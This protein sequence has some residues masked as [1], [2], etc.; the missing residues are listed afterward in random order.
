MMEAVRQ[1]INHLRQE[2]SKVI[3][4]QQV[5]CDQCVIALLCRGHALLEG[6]PGVAKTLVV[7]TLS[8]IL[9]LKFQR[10]QCTPDL[11]PADIIGTNVLN[12]A[13][14]AFN[15]HQGPV[16]TDLLL[17]DEVNRMPPRTQAGLLECM[18]E[19][20][21]TIDG[22]CCPL[23]PV[24]TVFATQNPI[25]FEGTYPL[26]EAQLDR[27]LLKVKVD[28]PG[29]NDEVQ[30]LANVQNGF[31]ARDLNSVEWAPVSAEMLVE[32]Q[33]EI[34]A[35]KVEKTLFEYIVK[36]IRLTRDWPALSLGASPRAAIYLMTVA[37]AMA[38]M[39]GRDFLIPDDVKSAA[40]PVLRHR[41]VLRPEA[42]LE[43]VTADQ[44]VAE[45]LRAVEVPK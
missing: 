3:V 45:I 34:K 23:S 8:R 41:I 40:P 4:G 6:A 33:E 29:A 27:F 25:E 38:A 17:V 22:V 9:Q 7:K 30:L 28:Y 19:Y 21:A 16:F 39:D 20:Q 11:M 1:L 36:I 2:M 18:E 35:I 26:P 32:A 14:G 10:V 5:F 15:L 44:V 24:F 43:G 37:K 42:D 13:S 31:D 12:M